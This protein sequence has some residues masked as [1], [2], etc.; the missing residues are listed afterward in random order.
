MIIFYENYCSSTV[1]LMFGEIFELSY[2]TSPFCVDLIFDTEE[3]DED[4]DF[5]HDQSTRR[6]TGIHHNMKTLTILPR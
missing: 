6:I 1:N 4:E 2:N 3:T 5:Q